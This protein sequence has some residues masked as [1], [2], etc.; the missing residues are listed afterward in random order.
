M[1]AYVS[2]KTF[3][4]GVQALRIHGLPEKIDRSV[5]ISKSGA[6]QAALLSAFRFLRLI[7]SKNVVQ[8]TLEELHGA[9]EGSAA[10]KEVLGSILRASYAE[11]FE[12]G[13]ET[14]TPTQFAAAIGNYGPTGSTRDRAERFFIKAAL[15]CGIEMSGR[16]TARRPRG[17]G[18]KTNGTT[19]RLTRRNPE[20]K[21]PPPPQ[22][23][24]ATVAMKAIELPMAG[25]SLTLSGRFNPFEL[26]G[27]ERELV[28]SIIDTMNGFESKT[29]EDE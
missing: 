27:D 25:G 28:F 2:F 26:V 14:V 9:S 7:D 10:E 21:R 16:L 23:D 29:K 1:A 13:L 6:D 18:T 19:Q 8:P 12:L 4:S 17:T 20:D 11:L 15:Y 5:W 22:G 24:Q 3:Q